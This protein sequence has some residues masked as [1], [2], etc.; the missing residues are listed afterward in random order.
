MV[1]TIA[2]NKQILKTSIRDHKNQESRT[3]RRADVSFLISK[4]VVKS[5]RG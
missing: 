1:R 3:K 4:K 5:E 2:G